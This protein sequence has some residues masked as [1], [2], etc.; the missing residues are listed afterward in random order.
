MRSLVAKT[1]FLHL[2]P[3]LLAFVP[4][5]IWKIGSMSGSMIA[6]TVFSGLVAITRYRIRPY[7]RLALMVLLA[8]SGLCTSVLC[9]GAVQVSKSRGP[10]LPELDTTFQWVFF[11]NI[12]V[13]CL[14][15]LVPIWIRRSR[16]KGLA[17]CSK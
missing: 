6:L 2:V 1:V 8:S 4:M 3:A 16:S 11:T 12:C 7:N 5:V 14:A 13:F 15:L 17:S 9:Y 10:S